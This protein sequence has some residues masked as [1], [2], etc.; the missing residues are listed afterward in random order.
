[1]AR[2]LLAALFAVF[3]ADGVFAQ[4]M[5]AIEA[6]HRLAEKFCSRCHAVGVTGESPHPDA[7]PLR[8]IVAKGQVENL[9]EALGEG[10]VVGHPEM[11]Q[12]QFGPGDVGALI[13]Y[14]KSLSGKG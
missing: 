2:A 11:P 1:M 5:P 12:F 13:S 14:L 8:V 10:I 3:L 7:P 9:E 4:T 6:G